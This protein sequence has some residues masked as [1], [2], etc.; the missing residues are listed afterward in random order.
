VYN[1]G[2]G[3]SSRSDST[4]SQS[5]NFKNQLEQFVSGVRRL[6]VRPRAV[7]VMYQLM[8]GISILIII[9]ISSSSSSTRLTH[10]LHI[11]VTLVADCC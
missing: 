8:Y 2:S 5:V 11:N 10:V 3:A 1:D 7:P 6:V 9:I 4:H